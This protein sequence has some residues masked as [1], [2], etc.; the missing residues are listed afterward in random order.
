VLAEAKGTAIDKVSP[1]QSVVASMRDR[2]ERYTADIAEVSER[3]MPHLKRMKPQDILDNARNVEQLDRVARRTFELD[4][5]P[6]ARGPLSLEILGSHVAVQING[7]P[8]L[9]E[10]S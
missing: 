10:K 5:N 2:A 1:F 7:P 9:P 6:P 4:T 3:V 8:R